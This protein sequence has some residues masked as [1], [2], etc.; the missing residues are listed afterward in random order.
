M[1][2]EVLE[3]TCVGDLLELLVEAG[4]DTTTINVNNA[5]C[6]RFCFKALNAFANN[7]IIREDWM[8]DAYQWHEEIRNGGVA[9]VLDEDIVNL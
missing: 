9:T 2:F 7:G 4:L 5:A 1:E 6:G 3:P 8:E